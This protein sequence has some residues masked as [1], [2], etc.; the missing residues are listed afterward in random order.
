[1]D[2]S[3]IENSFHQNG[4]EMR[5]HMT[6]LYI[7]YFLLVTDTLA[8]QN[9]YFGTIHEMYNSL[10]EFFVDEFAK[11]NWNLQLNRDFYRTQYG[12]YWFTSRPGGCLTLYIELYWVVG[13]CVCV[14]GLLCFP[15]LDQSSLTLYNQ[16]VCQRWKGNY[17]IRSLLEPV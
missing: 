17:C 13:M 3:V 6:Y 8:P 10:L 9:L 2:E 4:L 11:Q 16:T 7:L 5:Y 12:H 1:M 14:C 15:P